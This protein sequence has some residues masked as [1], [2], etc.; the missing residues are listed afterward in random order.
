VRDGDWLRVQTVGEDMLEW[1]QEVV[2]GYNG[3]S[4]CGDWRIRTAEVK[5]ATVLSSA[6]TEKPT[7]RQRLRWR[8][9]MLTSKRGRS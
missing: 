6:T 2:A 9:I 8:W 1:A 4:G 3:Q 7:L 5:P